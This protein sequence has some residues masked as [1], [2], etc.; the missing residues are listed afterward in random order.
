FKFFALAL[1]LGVGTMALAQENQEE[2]K[3][4]Y[5]ITET[6]NVPH[7]AVDNQGSSGTCWCFAGIG[8]VE[9]EILRM[10]GKEFNLSEMFVVRNAW[11]EKVNKFVRMHGNS[12]L[13]QGGEVCDVLYMIKKYGMMPEDAYNGKVIGEDRHMHSEMNEVVNGVARAVIKNGNKKL[14]PA[15]PKALEGVLDAYLGEVPDDFTVDGKKYNPKSFAE[16]Y[17]IDPAN[18]IE[19]CSFTSEPLYQPYVVEIPDNWTWTPAYNMPLDEMMQAVDYALEHGYTLGWAQDVSNPGFSRKE[20]VGIVPEDP[21]DE[22]LWK[23]I[24]AEKQVTD[25]IHQKAYDNWDAGDDHSMLVVGIAKDQNGTKYYK[26]KNSWGAAG[27][28]EG[29]WYCSEQ[30]LRQ[31]TIFFTLHKDALS[32]SLKGKLKI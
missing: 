3:T 24:V 23:E 4:V 19:I 21:K 16:A 28:Y 31:Y 25:E 12:T 13:S 11:S 27:P 8:F 7:T 30:Y 14:S 17:P 2:K 29:Y 1:L 22:N 26:I 15:Y 9:A 10:Y 18:Y 20:G 5:Q 6:V 32:K